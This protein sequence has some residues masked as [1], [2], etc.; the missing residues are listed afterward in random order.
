MDKIRNEY[1]SE[2]LKVATFMENFNGE[3]LEM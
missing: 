3:S 1:I 2:S